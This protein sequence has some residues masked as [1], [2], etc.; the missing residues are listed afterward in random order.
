MEEAQ[1]TARMACESDWS[2]CA[3]N[4]QLEKSRTW[5]S[6]QVACKSAVE[7]N[8]RYGEPKWPWL[9]FSTYHSGNDYIKSGKAVA[10]EPD[11]Q[12]QNVFGAMVH[13]EVICTY[14]LRAQR[15]TD[16]QVNPR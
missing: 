12:M 5:A 3:D 4:T 16:L 14:D 13:S 10:I 9:S 6:V 8:A 11:V 7:N 2:K 1:E 15:V